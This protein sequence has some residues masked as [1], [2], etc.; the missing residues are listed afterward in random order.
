[1]RLPGAQPITAKEGVRSVPQGRR[2]LGIALLLAACF[3]TVMLDRMAQLYLGP[4]LVRQLRLSPSEIGLLAGA[5][6]ICWAVSTFVFGILSD[7][8]GRKRLIVP[9]MVGFSLLSWCS[10]FARD[11]GELLIVRA[12]LGL[13][14]GPCWSVIM[15]LMEESSSPARRGRNI[16][17]VVCAGPLIGAAI[18]PILTIQ[19]AEHLGWRGAFFAAGIPGLLLAAAVAVY[20]PEPRR[21][22]SSGKKW[23]LGDV[24]QVVRIPAMWLCF[25][26]ALFLTVWVFAFNTFAPLYLTETLHIPGAEMGAILGASGLGG[27]LYC[28]LWPA[29]SDRV[30]RRPAILTAGLIAVML[31]LL[32]IA[33]HVLDLHVTGA[34]LAGGALLT[35]SGPAIAALIMI[36]VPVEIAP[37][38]LAAT[39]IGFVAIGGDAVG[40]TLGPIAGGY[41]SQHLGLAAPLGLAAASAAGIV[42]IG[43]FL[44]ETHITGIK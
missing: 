28:L 8:I 33:P 43:F 26:A 15:A 31:P 35:T 29:L 16:G 3:G 9:A 6:S 2:E 42:L 37:R 12:L 19:V 32:F 25:F 7:H 23:S 18:G 1:M 36:V 38:S 22:N 44:R 27:F 20:V 24:M 30:G 21:A 5:V 13:A 39:A 17:I 41:L 14:E 40:A 4:Y 34:V 11:F 10:G